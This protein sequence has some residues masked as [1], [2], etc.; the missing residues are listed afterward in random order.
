MLANCFVCVLQTSLDWAQYAED[1]NRAEY[2]CTWFCGPFYLLNIM[3]TILGL[4]LSLLTNSNKVLMS[5][6][7][8]GAHRAA[9]VV[10][11]MQPC[12]LIVAST[13]LPATNNMDWLATPCFGH[14]MSTKCNIFT[15]D[16]S[17]SLLVCSKNLWEFDMCTELLKNHQNS[18]LSGLWKFYLWKLMFAIFDALD[19]NWFLPN[20]GMI[21]TIYCSLFPKMELWE[22]YIIFEA[23]I[24][25]CCY[26]R[27]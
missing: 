18:V 21:S 17:K 12:T 5:S 25:I 27:L 2:L 15:H 20:L 8:C 6:S 19:F 26:S 7:H 22:E 10:L 13:K 4:F 23:F 24:Y 14:Q 16:T 3:A 11:S 9:R 1:G